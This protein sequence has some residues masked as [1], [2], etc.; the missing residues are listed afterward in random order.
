MRYQRIG[1]APWWMG[2][3]AQC[4]VELQSNK[5]ESIKDV[6][7]ATLDFF[8]RVNP[9][10]VSEHSALVKQRS[11]SMDG[12]LSGFFSKHDAFD[13]YKPW[14]RRFFESARRIVYR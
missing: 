12:L 6:P 7:T 2:F 4:I 10:F 9:P 13:D 3:G 5:Y 1:E 14:H 11:T 8:R